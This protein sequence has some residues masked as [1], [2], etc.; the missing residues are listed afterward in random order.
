MQRKRVSFIFCQR[1][2]VILVQGGSGY[3]DRTAYG[4]LSSALFV[5]SRA[6]FEGISLPKIH[7]LN[8]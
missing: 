4:T 3:L 2:L 7:L 8:C 6:Y 1:L 5:I